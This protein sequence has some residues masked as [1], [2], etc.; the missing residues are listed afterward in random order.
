MIVGIKS[1]DFTSI[2]DLSS[3]YNLDGN[4]NYAEEKDVHEALS[5]CDQTL[6]SC[7]IPMTKTNLWMLH[8]LFPNACKFVQGVLVLIITFVIVI[9]SDNIIDLFKDFAAMQ[10]IAELDNVAYYLADHGYFGSDLKEDASTVKEIKI[11]DDVPK[12]CRLPLR[13]VVLISLLGLMMSVFVGVVVVRQDKGDFFYDKYPMCKVMEVEQIATIS[14]GICHGGLQNTFQCGF[15]GGDCI[16]K[17]QMSIIP[18][19]VPYEV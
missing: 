14:D 5:R 16:G 6:L 17:F 10:V 7:S 4:N 13:P 11:T 19:F 8:I 2:R 9:Q 12:I 3:K 1:F 15:D 18:M